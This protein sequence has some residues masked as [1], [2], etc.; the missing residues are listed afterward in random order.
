MPSSLDPVD[1]LD[2]AAQ[3]HRTHAE[4]DS[5]EWADAEHARFRSS[6]SRA[7]Y[8]AFLHLKSRLVPVRQWPNGFPSGEVHG[9]V[10]R[11]L[12]GALGD[13]HRIP[14][15]LNA[16]KEMRVDADYE[17]KGDYD[18]VFAEDRCDDAD[19]VIRWVNELADDKL[20]DIANRL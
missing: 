11:A 3:L 9:K 12:R 2:V 8:G 14:S 6:V 16:L 10:I 20:T 4:L 1:V 15:R 5:V 17:L 19:S 13:R 18:R 7:Y